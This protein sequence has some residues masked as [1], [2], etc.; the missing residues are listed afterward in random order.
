MR[1]TPPHKMEN[2]QSFLAANFEF[3]PEETQ[4]ILNCFEKKTLK[5]GAYFLTEGQYCKTVAF[6]E[7]GG[8]FFYQ[9]M[10]GEEKVCD[11]AFEGDWISQ[12]KSLINN[13]PSELSIKAL[14][15]SEIYWLD[16]TAMDKLSDK[17][18]KVLIIRTK[19]AEQY[20]TQSAERADKLAT[21]KA[22]ERYQWLLDSHPKIHQRVP[23]YYIA[24]YLGIK[25]QSLSRI[26]AVK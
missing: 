16:A 12:Y 18:P 4:Q 1:I 8:F 2:F 24:S 21:L 15:D 13:L 23:Q 26:R 25:P 10:D 9:L 14:V 7:K 11:F 20:F 6:V 17:V 5:K 3:N 19:L 22:E